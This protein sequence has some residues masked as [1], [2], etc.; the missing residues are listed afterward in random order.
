[1]MFTGLQSGDYSDRLISCKLLA[2][3]LGLVHP[4]TKDELFEYLNLHWRSLRGYV[5]M[6]ISLEDD[7]NEEVSAI[8]RIINKVCV[9]KEMREASKG[10][11]KS[12]CS[13]LDLSGVLQEDSSARKRPTDTF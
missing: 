1:M 2:S 5:Q 13:G 10:R 6:A 9:G 4:Q 3:L 7:W 11:K 8:C 12:F